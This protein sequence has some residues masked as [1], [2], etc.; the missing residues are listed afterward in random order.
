MPDW[1]APMLATLTE[2]R[3]SDRNWIFERKFD[4]IRCLAFVRRGKVSL[5]TR[6]RLSANERYPE[7]ADALAGQDRDAFVVDG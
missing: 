6:N 3:F 1:A 2:E 5:L 4:G 7:V